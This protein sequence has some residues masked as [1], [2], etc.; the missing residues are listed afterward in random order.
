MWR[1]ELTQHPRAADAPSLD[2]CQQQVFMTRNRLCLCGVFPARQS[3]MISTCSPNRCQLFSLSLQI[4]EASIRP[5][6][7]HTTCK[8]GIEH[9]SSLNQGHG[10]ATSS[11][12]PPAFQR[13]H[14]CQFLGKLL[15]FSGAFTNS[16]EF[17]KHTY[18]PRIT[19][20]TSA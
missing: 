5:C 7:L 15:M 6:A 8:T 11:R 1:Q 20:K 14:F 16:H 17:P 4:Q 3:K 12:Q 18:P 19:M 9:P 13:L 10:D 2:S